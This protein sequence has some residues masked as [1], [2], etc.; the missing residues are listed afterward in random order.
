MIAAY[1]FMLS[2]VVFLVGMF[3]SG[4]DGEHRGAYIF[5]FFALLLMIL[6]GFALALNEVGINPKVTV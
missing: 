5:L 4:K 1:V 2:S 3:T 6:S